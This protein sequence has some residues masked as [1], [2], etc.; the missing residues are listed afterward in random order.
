MSNPE[1]LIEL[2]DDLRV[3]ITNWDG[4]LEEARKA[5]AKK[6]DEFHDCCTSLQA[7][8]VRLEGEVH[9]NNAQ[10]DRVKDQQLATTQI[11]A[12]VTL[13]VA[14][15][16][17]VASELVS[18]AGALLREWMTEEQSAREW[19]GRAERNLELAQ[20][21]LNIA[22]E[23]L[24]KAALD[25]EAAQARYRS[26]QARPGWT[27]SEGKYY[28]PD[29]SSES[30]EV[31]RCIHA[32][33]QAQKVVDTAQQ[34]VNVC[35]ADLNR[36]RARLNLCANNIR[37]I[38]FGKSVAEEARSIAVTA[39]GHND[40]SELLLQSVN[41]KADEILANQNNQSGHLSAMQEAV[42]RSLVS[43]S[44]SSGVSGRIMGDA[45]ALRELAPQAQY[46]LACLI[47]K[48]ADFNYAK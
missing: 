18:H 30:Q 22:L 15:A 20:Y 8:A 33:T 1:I 45:E 46:V 12:G 31:S 10:V 5:S 19:V 7:R 9:E 40:Q 32:Y 4:I 6:V 21:Q 29:C 11:L 37:I 36:A 26:C 25:L 24:R 39:S 44:L 16:N 23:D 38:Q 47:E 35:Q 3:D 17:K 43:L 48:L 34:R 2:M 41:S 28:P 27:N 42:E 13:R 14:N